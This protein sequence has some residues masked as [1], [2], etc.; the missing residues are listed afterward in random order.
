MKKFTR[1]IKNEQMK[2]EEEEKKM[3]NLS[4]DI[5]DANVRSKIVI[6]Y[7]ESMT[8]PEKKLNDVCTLVKNIFLRY[9]IK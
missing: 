8:L 5:P 4:K 9:M 2:I 3:N 6:G 7:L 1:K